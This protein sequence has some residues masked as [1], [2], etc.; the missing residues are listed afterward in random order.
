MPKFQEQIYTHEIAEEKAKEAPKLKKKRIQRVY[1]L[2]PAD[3]D[4]IDIIVTK[5]VNDVL[6]CVETGKFRFKHLEI[7]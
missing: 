4:D 6:D 2:Y 1:V 7:T 3:L 5:N